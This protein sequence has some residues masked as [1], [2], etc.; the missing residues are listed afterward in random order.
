MICPICNKEF[1]PKEAWQ[2]YCSLKCGTWARNNSLNP[3]RE[4]FEFYCAHCGK[5]VITAPYNDQR[6]KYCSQR[7]HDR[8]KERRKEE[9]RRRLRGN[10]GMS[11]AMCLGSLIRRERRAL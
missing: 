6:Y 5:L 4:P 8:A 9:R 7:C 3:P 11:S 10:L 1:E 2:K